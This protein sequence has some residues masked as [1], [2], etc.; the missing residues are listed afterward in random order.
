M[1]RQI[2][3][4]TGVRPLLIE[5][6]ARRRRVENRFI[7]VLE[8]SGFSEIILP[9][10]DYV[11]AYGP[12]ELGVASK[13]AY[14][15]VDR[16]GELVSLRADFT[17]MVA[18]ALAP[19]IDAG[20]R[21]LRVYYRGDVIRWEPSRLGASR[22]MFQIGAEIIGDDSIEA[23]VATLHLAAELAGDASVVYTDAR[24]MNAVAASSPAIREALM[25]KRSSADPLAA[26]LLAE[27]ARID[28]VRPFAPQAADRLAAIAASLDSRFVLHLGDVEDVPGYYTGIRFSVY[29]GP[30][31]SKI[32]Q[33]GRYDDLY[34]RLGAPAP[35]VGFTFT[36]DDLD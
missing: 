8:R 12:V 26:K 7:D 34:E 10:I 33:G 22:E 31:R 17:P 20:Q 25:T 28:D 1:V 6:A 15:F 5:A 11:E 35:A 23:D 27:T 19:V 36:I 3:Y 9:V 21:P 14:R 4:P 18:R 24:V 32:A 16:D 29:A 2:R 13:R 30:S